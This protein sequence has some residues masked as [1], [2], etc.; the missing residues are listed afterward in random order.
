MYGFSKLFFNY[1]ILTNQFV[2]VLPNDKPFIAD[3]INNTWH[4]N[5][6]VLSL[7]FTIR[8]ENSLHYFFGNAEKFNA[9]VH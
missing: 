5:D 6:I 2:K 9:F 8:I 7:I 4:K 3:A 1:K